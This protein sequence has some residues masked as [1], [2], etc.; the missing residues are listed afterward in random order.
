LDPS[1]HSYINRDIPLR[2]HSIFNQD[3]YA[4]TFCEGSANFSNP[5]LGDLNE[6]LQFAPGAEKVKY[7][8]TIEFIKKYDRVI[9]K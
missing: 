2:R 5:L 1:H 3:I 9:T 7:E 8:N 4:Y 6:M